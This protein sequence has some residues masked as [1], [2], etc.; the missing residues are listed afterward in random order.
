MVE[1]EDCLETTPKIRKDA[2]VS[3][4]LSAASSAVHR[5]RVA[6]LTSW[7]FILHPLPA[8]QSQAMKRVAKKAVV[9]VVLLSPNPPLDGLSLA[10]IL[11]KLA[12]SL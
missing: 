7:L 2:A 6:L 9:V 11:A 4:G 5:A 12:L 10:L 3:V 8:T 1:E